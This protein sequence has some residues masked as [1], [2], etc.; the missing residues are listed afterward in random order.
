MKMAKLLRSI[1]I[2]IFTISIRIT[3]KTYFWVMFY[4]ILFLN[5]LAC[6]LICIFINFIL[7][8]KKTAQKFWQDIM[9]D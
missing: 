2:T 1:I 6:S 8:D 4:I 5:Y 7:K 3:V 9:K